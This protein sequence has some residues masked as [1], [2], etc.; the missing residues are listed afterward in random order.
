MKKFKGFTLIELLV[1][2]AIIG[3]LASVAIVNLNSA[4][5]KAHAANVQS[6][7]SSLTSAIIVCH[8]D[9]LELT[10]NDA[11]EDC[12]GEATDLP[13]QGE[14]ICAGSESVW[15]TISGDGWAYTQ[16]AAATGCTSDRTVPEW[17]IRADDFTS[18]RFISCNEDGCVAETTGGYDDDEAAVPHSPNPIP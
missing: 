2:I 3:I 9:G 11:G 13:V 6:A 10:I 12:D 18:A 1:V 14:A 17:A 16:T 8:D 15:P 7:L 4:R 5:R